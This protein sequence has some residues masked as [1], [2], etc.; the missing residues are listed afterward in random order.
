MVQDEKLKNTYKILKFMRM[1][2]QNSMTI[3]STEAKHLPLWWY[4]RKMQGSLNLLGSIIQISVNNVMAIN[5]IVEIQY[6]WE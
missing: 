5:L 6:F 1:S 4:Y 2:L 3:Q